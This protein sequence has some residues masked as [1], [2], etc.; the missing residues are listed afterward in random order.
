M[1]PYLADVQIVLNLPARRYTLT[2]R[3]KLNYEGK[4]HSFRRIVMHIWH[5]LVSRLGK[6]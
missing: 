1:K 2:R 4:I 5:C 6:A 3:K